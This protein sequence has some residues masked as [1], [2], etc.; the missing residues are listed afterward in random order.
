MDRLLHIR[1]Q[2]IA[3]FRYG[4][5]RDLTATH[6]PAPPRVGGLL[7]TASDFNGQAKV[8]MPGLVT[9]ALG[10]GEFQRNDA[11]EACSGD[12]DPR[13]SEPP[14]WRRY[15]GGHGPLKFDSSDSNYLI[16]IG[17]F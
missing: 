15:A 10:Q 3:P 17:A 5:I 7:G 12:R 13:R 1:S 2:M 4:I 16:L 11:P 9:E 6:H 8:L 14:G